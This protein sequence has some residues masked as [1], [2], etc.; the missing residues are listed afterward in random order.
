MI[1]SQITLDNIGM[2]MSDLNFSFIRNTKCKCE[3]HSPEL[4]TDEDRENKG[5]TYYL[6]KDGMPRINPYENE[7]TNHCTFECSLSQ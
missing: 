2:I 4:Y 7:L 1:P 5:I 6:T 3:K